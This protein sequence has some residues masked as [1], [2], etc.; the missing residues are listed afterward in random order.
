MLTLFQTSVSFFWL[1]DWMFIGV[2]VWGLYFSALIETARAKIWHFW[3]P[4]AIGLGAASLMFCSGWILV[5]I[6]VEMAALTYLMACRREWIFR[7]KEG[8]AVY[9]GLFLGYAAVVLLIRRLGFDYLITTDYI[10]RYFITYVIGLTIWLY[11]ALRR[12]RGRIR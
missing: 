3:I 6:G 11:L 5:P 9:S 8:F 1:G 7:L 12:K 4:V 2:F 10:I